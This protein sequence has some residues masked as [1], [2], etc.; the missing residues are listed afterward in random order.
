MKLDKHTKL[1]DDMTTTYDKQ[2]K[3]NLNTEEKEQIR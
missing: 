3:D 1:P 2:S